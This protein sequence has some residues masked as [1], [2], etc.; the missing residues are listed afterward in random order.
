[1][2]AAEEAEEAG[3]DELGVERFGGEE[4]ELIGECGEVLDIGAGEE[5]ENLR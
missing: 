1:M 5:G 4:E 2:A 3:E